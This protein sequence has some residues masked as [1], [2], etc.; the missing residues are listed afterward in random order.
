M[1]AIGNQILFFSFGF[2]VPDSR[3]ETVRVLPN[4]RV[5]LRGGLRDARRGRAD[6]ARQKRGFVFFGAVLRRIAD[7]PAC[8]LSEKQRLLPDAP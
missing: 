4:L 2:L 7:M 8:V 5:A 6:H 3:P 1:I